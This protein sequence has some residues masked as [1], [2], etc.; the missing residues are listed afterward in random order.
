VTR[1][2]YFRAASVM[3]EGPDGTVIAR[4]TKLL[5]EVTRRGLSDTVGCLLQVSKTPSSQVRSAFL[6]SGPP[7]PSSNFQS[8]ATYFRS[9][10]LCSQVWMPLPAGSAVVLRTKV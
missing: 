8:G 9:S 5:Q 4:I 2:L 1:K 6:L 7:R 10:T 3:E